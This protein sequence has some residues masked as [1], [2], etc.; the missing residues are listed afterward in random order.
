MKK[1]ISMVKKSLGLSDY[2]RTVEPRILEEMRAIGYQP[3]IFIELIDTTGQHSSFVCNTQN[4]VPQFVHDLVA[5][6][7]DAENILISAINKALRLETF[8]AADLLFSWA[9]SASDDFSAGVMVGVP[10]ASVVKCPFYVGY[11]VLSVDQTK[12]SAAAGSTTKFSVLQAF[13]ANY[14]N[15]SGNDSLRAAIVEA[16]TLAICRVGGMLGD[17]VGVKESLGIA[18]QCLPYSIFLKSAE[19]ALSLKMQGKTIPKRLEKFIGEDNGYLKR[20]VCPEP[21]KRFDIGPSGDVL[22]CCGHWLPTSIG[23]FQ[24]DAVDDILNSQMAQKIR[25]SVTDGTYKFCNHLECG[26]LIQ[27]SLPLREEIV[28]PVINHAIATKDFRLKGVD[29]LLFAY[30]RSCNLSC[31]SCRTER[32]IEKASESEEKAQAVEEKLKP[33]LPSIKVLNLN[34]A[35]ELFASRPS[36]KIL[37]LINDEFCPDLVLD[38]ISN[39]TLLSEQEWNKFPGIHNKIRSIRISTDGATKPTFEKLR[40]L[41]NWDVFVAN[42]TFLARL[43]H[44][45]VVPQ[46]KFSFTYQVDNYLEM[47]EFVAFAKN[48]NCDFVIFERLQNLGA[49]SHEHFLERAVHRPE[50]RLHQE[51]LQ[52]IGDPVFLDT[53]V[54]HDF[55]YEGVMNLSREKVR[56]RLSSALPKR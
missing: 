18:M 16:F 37:E 44:E 54:W 12:P 41:G 27:E 46:L 24:R 38:I 48:F 10:L 50:H 51:F 21:F 17:Y 55:D 4:D 49:F 3:F 53:A 43:R 25:A 30:D 23:N 1:V 40:R 11:P 45:G 2:I 29:H 52:V 7:A 14:A 8:D 26:A 5:S 22:M 32:V 56:E 31:P 9:S 15:T 13:V 33:L 47:A 28:D 6:K 19:H 34:P 42:M 20:F 39:G 35:G 36:R